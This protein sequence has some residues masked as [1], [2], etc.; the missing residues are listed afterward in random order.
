M[1]KDEEVV[2]ESKK[3]YKRGSPKVVSTL[4][5]PSARTDEKPTPST[6]L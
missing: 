6:N 5:S 3:E 2:E 4:G 1:T